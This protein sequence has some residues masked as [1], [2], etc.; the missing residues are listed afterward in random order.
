MKYKY[1]KL[2]IQFIEM[3]QK[4][5]ISKTKHIIRFNQAC[6]RNVCCV[7]DKKILAYLVDKDKTHAFVHF[8]NYSPKSKIYYDITLGEYGKT[9]YDYY[10]VGEVKMDF[11][12]CDEMLNHNKKRLFERA[13][14][15]KMKNKYYGEI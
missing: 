8:I 12:T 11:S 10:F 7:K 2:I 13:T 14:H 5:N 1:E 15:K 3:H 6:H 9:N 4:I